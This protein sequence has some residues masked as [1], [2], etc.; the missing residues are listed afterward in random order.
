MTQ[1]NAS[2]NSN[3]KEYLNFYCGLLSEPGFA[4]LL[5]GQ[6]GSGKTWFIKKYCENLTN[7]GHKYLYVNL[8]GMTSCSEIEEAFLQQAIPILSSKSMALFRNFTTQALKNVAKIDVNGDK[9]DRGTLNASFTDVSLANYLINFDKNILIFDELERC[10]II[11]SNVLGYINSFV[12]HQDLKVIIVANEVELEKI[13]NYKDIKEKVIGI[14][15][16]IALDFEGALE[17]F[18]TGVQSADVRHFLSDNTINPRL[19]L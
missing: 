14:T 9:K 7:N 5:K 6:W 10:N 11:L 2:I 19:L 4:V 12:E 8:N 13:P 1:Y 18:I 17:K 16:E 15:L 3:I